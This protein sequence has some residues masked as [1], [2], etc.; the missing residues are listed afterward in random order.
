M[1]AFDRQSEI[2]SLRQRLSDAEAKRAALSDELIHL[3][4]WLP[5]MRR[6]FGN[7]FYYSHPE[8]PDEGIAH[9]TGN[10]SHGIGLPTLREFMR[11]ERE[12]ARIKAVLG[13]L[14]NT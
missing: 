1:D 13:R 14:E 4:A 5:E 7:P 3:T 10:N 12:L 9:Y 6:A 11:V 2:A 8:E